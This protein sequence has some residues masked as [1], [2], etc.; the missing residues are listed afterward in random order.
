MRDQGARAIIA[1]SPPL[2]IDT[3]GWEALPSAGVPKAEL[4]LWGGLR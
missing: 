1:E 2:G 3:T 4:M